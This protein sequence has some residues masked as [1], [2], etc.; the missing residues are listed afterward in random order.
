[1]VEAWFEK[2]DLSFQIDRQT[3]GKFSADT[4]SPLTNFSLSIL[5]ELVNHNV[6]ITTPTGWLKPISLLAYMVAYETNRCVLVFSKSSSRSEESPFTHH[7]EAYNALMNNGE[8]VFVSNSD[9]FLERRSPL[10]RFE[11]KFSLCDA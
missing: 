3:M 5:K 6:I 1:M 11:K 8:Y 9:G 2:F 4:L 10:C 7:C